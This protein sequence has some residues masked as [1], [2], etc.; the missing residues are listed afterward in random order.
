MKNKFF[1]LIL[2]FLF[3]ISFSLPCFALSHN[4]YAD[5]SQSN[6]TVQNL[7]SHAVNCTSFKDSKYVV[8][9]PAQNSYFIVWGDLSANGSVISSSNE[10]NY[11]EYSRDSDYQYRYYYST[12]D[13]FTLSVYDTVVTNLENIGMQSSLYDEYIFREKFSDFSILLLI[14]SFLIFLFLL[15]RS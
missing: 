8:Y 1:V 5:L 7:I 10:V 15:K 14:I 4:T 6:T 11:I 9:T 3:L 13:N 2:T 12:I